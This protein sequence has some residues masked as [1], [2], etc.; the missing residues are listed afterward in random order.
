ML[1]AFTNRSRNSTYVTPNWACAMIMPPSTPSTSANTVSNGSATTS[2]MIFGSTSSSIGAMP[3]V[4]M[5][6]I[7]SVTAMVPICA[8]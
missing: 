4:R 7:S 5:A 1:T 6:S 3:M 2:A 8:A